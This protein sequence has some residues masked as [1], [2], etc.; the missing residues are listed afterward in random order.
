MEWFTY[1]LTIILS[2]LGLLIGSLLA[3]WSKEEIYL[4]KEY[5][6]FFQLLIFSLVFVVYFAFFPILVAISLIILSF[7]FIYLFWHKRELN[8]LDYIVFSGLVVISSLQSQAHFY[9]TILITFFSILSGA[10]FYALHTRVKF[11]RTQKSKKTSKLSKQKR[12]EMRKT[13]FLKPSADIGK[14]NSLDTILT[15]LFYKYLFFPVL[16]ILAYGVAELIK[17]III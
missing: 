14:N 1:I 6:P 8:I 2:F 9:I 15:A 17:I 12:R 11:N 3:H 4:V 10:L 5:I 13:T 16:A 7:G